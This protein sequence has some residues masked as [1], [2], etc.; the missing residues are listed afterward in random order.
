MK[1]VKA[2]RAEKTGF[3][4]IDLGHETCQPGQGLVPV[5][6]IVKS[7]P[8]F[9]YRGAIAI[10]HEPENFDPRADCQAGLESVRRWLADGR[11]GELGERRSA[12]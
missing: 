3:P 11:A 4:F 5:E 9:G 8:A 2:R 1:D 10:E 7:L 12:G 6:A